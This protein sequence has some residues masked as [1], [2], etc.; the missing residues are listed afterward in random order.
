M[1]RLMIDN[2][3]YEINWITFSDGAIT[4]KIDNL[5]EC[6]EKVFI[7]VDPSTPCKDVLN[8]VLLVRSA[9]IQNTKTS[10]YRVVLN[11][12]YLPYARA[13]R[14]FESGNPLPLKMFLDTV[15]YCFD[16][17]YTV[18]VHNQDWV[19][20]YGLLDK[21]Q[22]ECV[23]EVVR[24]LKQY[25]YVVAP[26]K[27][28]LK[29]IYE[30]GMPTITA[31][32]VRDVSTGRIVE[33]TLDV[34]VDLSGKKL[35]IVDDILDGGGTFIPLT[36]KIKSLGASVD[37]YVTHLIAA[38]GLDIFKGKLDNLYCYHTVGKYVNQTDVLNF[39][40]GK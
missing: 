33:T 29:K 19:T 36:E 15:T 28:A 11:L 2:K 23:Q 8:E 13:D 17:L 20:R 35:L 4:C 31:T 38:K 24:N 22:H 27:G 9:V 14:V 34:D 30:L 25:D 21:P 5:P 32:K 40:L 16:L 3:P 7:T 18:D 37:L 1:I 10:I 12:P 26:D 6:C 39:N